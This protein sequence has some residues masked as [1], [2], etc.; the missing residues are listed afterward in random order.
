[1]EHFYDAFD[2]VYFFILRRRLALS[3]TSI[4]LGSFS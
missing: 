2:S 4:S 1:M 3:H